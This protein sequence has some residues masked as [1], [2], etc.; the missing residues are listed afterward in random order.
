MSTVVPVFVKICAI[1]V[2]DPDASPTIV[3]GADVTQEKVALFRFE[4]KLISVVSPLHINCCIGSTLTFPCGFTVIVWITAGTFVHPT[5]AVIST[6]PTWSVLL[7][8]TNELNVTGLIPDPVSV[9]IP[10]TFVES[11]ISQL[12]T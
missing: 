5:F 6:V 8:K 10:V 7:N 3:P 2:P 4:V 9:V 12:I 1:L 11:V